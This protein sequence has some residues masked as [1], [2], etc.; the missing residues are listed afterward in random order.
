MNLKHLQSFLT[1]AEQG[2]LARAAAATDLAESLISRHISSLETAWGARLFERTGRGMV[3]SEFGKLMLPQVRAAMDQILR[4]DVTAKESAG[5]PTGTV[6]VGVLP[7]LATQLLPLLFADLRANAPEITLRAVEGFSGLLDEQLANGRLDL[8]V[9]NRYGFSTRRE[10]EVLGSADTYLIGRKG[11]ALMERK[12]IPFKALSTIPLV[13]PSVP[14][15]LRTNLNQLARRHAVKLNIVME[16][17][18]AGSMKDVT[19]SGH[20]YT[21]LPLMAVK[22]ELSQGRLEARPIVNPAIV[23]TIVLSVTSQRPLSLAARHVAT[24]I[25]ALAPKLVQ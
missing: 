23:R 9:I 7:S 25:R 15:G 16:V 17:D 13:L 2:S 19:Q 4:L 20:A 8:A 22:A 11:S 10:E 6:Q 21:L 14:N 3:L 24:R 18:S 1:V 12:S 5:V